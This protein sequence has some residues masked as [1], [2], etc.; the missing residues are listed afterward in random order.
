MKAEEILND[1]ESCYDEKQQIGLIHTYARIQIE[2]DRVSESELMVIVKSESK[3]YDQSERTCFLEGAETVL[4]QLRN[5]P[6][7]LD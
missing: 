3:N 7:T 5:R 4:R 6:I 2:K 1:I